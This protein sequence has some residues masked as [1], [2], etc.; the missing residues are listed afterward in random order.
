MKIR[1]LHLNG[2]FCAIAWL[3]T[4]ATVTSLVL[5]WEL[6]DHPYF[7]KQISARLI[8]VAPIYPGQTI[9]VERTY[10]VHVR[11]STV[12]TSLIGANQ[13]FSLP[14]ASFFNTNISCSHPMTHSFPTLI[15][16]SADPGIFFLQGYHIIPQNWLRTDI[17]QYPP[18]KIIVSGKPK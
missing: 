11:S 14:S 1:R 17:I 13:V 18:I 9:F 12:V 15:D 6:F 2:N 16:P 7:Y 5:Y 3:I 10:C 8:T 4:F